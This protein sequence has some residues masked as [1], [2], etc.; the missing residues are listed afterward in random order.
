[1]GVTGNDRDLK[2]FFI[3]KITKENKAITDF[4]SGYVFHR[5]HRVSLYRAGKSKR[6]HVEVSVQT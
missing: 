1:M 5:H 6:S 4:D 2:L 3:I